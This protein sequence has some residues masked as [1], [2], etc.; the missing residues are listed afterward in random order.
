[1]K[2][3]NLFVEVVGC[4]NKILQKYGDPFHMQNPGFP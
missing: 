3:G 4:T 2:R 1:M